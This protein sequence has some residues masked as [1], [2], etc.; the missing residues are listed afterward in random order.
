LKYLHRLIWYLASRL[1]VICCILGLMTIAFYYAMNFSNIYIVLKDGMS[2]RAK[3]IMMDTDKSPLYSYFSSSCI[4][5]GATFADTTGN[6]PDYKNFD[7]TGFDH[8]MAMEWMWCW[9]WENTATAIITETIPA[10]DGKIKQEA[11]SQQTEGQ[12][13]VPRWPST[14]YTVILKRE[15]GQWRINEFRK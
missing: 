4:D 8:R 5:S 10:I 14:K 7:I 12:N 3:V 15:N 13:S 1:L 6:A 11:R 9:P 2:E